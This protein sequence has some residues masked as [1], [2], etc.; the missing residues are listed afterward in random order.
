MKLDLCYWVRHDEIISSHYILRECVQM[1][2]RISICFHR[3]MVHQ[4]A[5][6]DVIALHCPV[7]LN[8][9]IESIN[10]RYFKYRLDTEIKTVWKMACEENVTCS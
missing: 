2:T 1:R 8:V 6:C 7:P 3:I 9:V 4:L 10:K 5:T